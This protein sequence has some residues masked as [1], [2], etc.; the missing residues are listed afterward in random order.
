[1]QSFCN[2]VQTVSGVRYAINLTLDRRCSQERSQTVL[3]SRD[4]PNVS[5]VTL[6]VFG[7]NIFGQELVQSAMNVRASETNNARKRQKW[8]LWE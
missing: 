6:V 8:L 3:F 4:C 1:M 2:T 7:L 5:L